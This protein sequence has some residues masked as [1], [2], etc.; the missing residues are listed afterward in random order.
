MQGS[1]GPR[2][3]TWTRT[4]TLH[5]QSVGEIAR[6]RFL[7]AY[8]THLRCGAG[9]P[10]SGRFVNAGPLVT[11]TVLDDW[12]FS[13]L[14]AGL[15]LRPPPP[16]FGRRQGTPWPLLSPG[17]AVRTTFKGNSGVA[18]S[19]GRAS[20]SGFAPEQKSPSRS[21]LKWIASG[22]PWFGMPPSEQSQTGN[23]CHFQ[24]DSYTRR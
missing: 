20:C 23:P 10:S 8:V 19:S 7:P 17:H 15:R 11:P 1:E 24:D 9:F 21:V 18:P 2:A 6:V 5:G 12:T 13:P 14:L 22:S 4:R 3:S 16:G